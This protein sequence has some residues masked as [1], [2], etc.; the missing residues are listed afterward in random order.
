[1]KK[2]ILTAALVALPF[3][4]NA[5]F[6]DA[7]WAKQACDAW[8]GSATLTNELGGDWASNDGGRGYKLIQMY[9]EQCGADSKVQ[10]NITNKDGKAIC[11]YG[12]KPDGKAVD[13]SMDYLMHAT[14]E[15][16]TCMGEGSF[17]CGA[18]GAMTTGK[19][20]FDG[21]KMEAMGVMGPFNAFLKLTGT[22]GG[23]KG[24]CN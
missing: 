13:N 2:L 22:I 11:T 19:L 1:M 6:M 23:E 17:G 24:A 8:N 18:M 12:G 4:A 7:S 3:S 10:L 16:W 14:D 21:P 5:G 15:D 9:R 20:K